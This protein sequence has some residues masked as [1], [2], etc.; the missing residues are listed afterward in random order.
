MES[1]GGLLMLALSIIVF[2]RIQKE[3]SKETDEQIEKKKIRKANDKIR[4][5]IIYDEMNKK[6]GKKKKDEVKRKKL[7]SKNKINKEVGNYIKILC[8]EINNIKNMV[9]TETI[10]KMQNILK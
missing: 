7:L 10:K 1:Y 8:N 4:K 6:K 9:I 3:K 5:K 2:N